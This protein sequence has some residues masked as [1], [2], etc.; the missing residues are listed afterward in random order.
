MH[1]EPGEEHTERGRTPRWAWI[2]GLIGAWLLLG[3]VAMALFAL[4]FVLG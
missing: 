4:V 3:F 1:V 2:R